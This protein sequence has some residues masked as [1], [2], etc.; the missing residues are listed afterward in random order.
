MQYQITHPKEEISKG[1]LV[2]FSFIGFILIIMVGPCS[3]QSDFAPTINP[4]K[5]I[6]TAAWPTNIATTPVFKSHQL[7]KSWTGTGMKTT[8]SFIMHSQPWSIEWKNDPTGMDGSSMGVFQIMAYQTNN[9]DIPTDIA[10]NPGEKDTDTCYIHTAGS[11]YLTINAANSNWSV[12]VYS[13]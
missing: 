4:T 8:E 9:P 10:D 5:T 11:F 1:R 6:P 12:K 13:R 3:A 7:I 2:F